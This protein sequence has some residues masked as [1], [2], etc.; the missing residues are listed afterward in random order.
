NEYHRYS[1]DQALRKV[2]LP[3]GTRVKMNINTQ[4]SYSNYRDRRH[5]SISGNGEAFFTVAHNT[6][7][8]FEISAGSGTI[9]VTGT[10]F[11]IW[12]Y[13]KNVVVTVTEGS[14]VVYNHGADVRL[15]SG[16][17]GEYGIHHQ[18]QVGSGN[19][20][21]ALAWKSGKLILDDLPLAKAMPQ[22][23]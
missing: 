15:T 21:Q 23:G 19:I 5:V 17:R 2:T 20:G 14:V 9:T 22:I 3:D 4:I 8:P 16:M 6:E 18:P 12:K 11:N 13:Q 7:H 1:A 10:A